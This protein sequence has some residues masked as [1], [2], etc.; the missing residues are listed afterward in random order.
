MNCFH[1]I[2]RLEIIFFV[3]W[4]YPIKYFITLTIRNILFSNWYK[5]QL[6]EA[7][8][9]SALVQLKCKFRFTNFPS[10]NG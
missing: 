3:K 9:L 4:I 5:L 8:L 7:I 10:L 1:T 2:F 6:E